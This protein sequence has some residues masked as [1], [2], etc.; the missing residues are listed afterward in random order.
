MIHLSWSFIR[1]RY[2]LYAGTLLTVICASMLMSSCLLLMFSAI[3][4]D[5]GPTRFQQADYLIAHP[6]TVVAELGEDR[7]TDDIPVIPPLSRE[8]ITEIERMLPGYSLYL[9]LTFYAQ[10]LDQQGNLLLNQGKYRTFGHTWSSYALT[11]DRLQAG[12]P[13]Q[14]PDEVV[15]DADL[16]R[17]SGYQIGDQVEVLT[18]AGIQTYTL[19]GI[20]K[21]EGGRAPFQGAMYF[22]ASHASLA[23]QGLPTAIGVKLNGASPLTE[24]QIERIEESMQVNVY[25]NQSRIKADSADVSL[26]YTGA[27]AVFGTMVGLT[28]F[29]AMF[30]LAST[31]SFSVQ[32]R[33]GDIALLRTIGS[34]TGQVKRM[35]ITETMLLSS[36]GAI[37]GSLLGSA[38]AAWLRQMFV[39]IGA[40]PSELTLISPR[41]T[42]GI[43]FGASLLISLLAA[44]GSSGS[45]TGM[46]ILK[47]VK[48]EVEPPAKSRW[49]RYMLGLI[50][51]G[52]GLAILIFTPM[53]GGMG[54]GM[55]FIVIAL[56]LITASLCGPILLALLHA[57]TR[58]LLVLVPG[59]A[60]PLA[61]AN[62]KRN[63]S[64]LVKVAI[65]LSMLLAVNAVMLLTS[66]WLMTLTEEHAA[67]RRGGG[68]QIQLAGG[69]GIPLPFVEQVM[70]QT[71]I[72]GGY[73]L[74]RSSVVVQKGSNL[75]EISAAGLYESG[76]VPLL[77]VVSGSLL[78]IES[79]GK[80]AISD[81][82]S[83]SLKVEVQD[84]LTLRLADGTKAEFEIGAIFQRM[85]GFEEIL[86]PW[87]PLYAHSDQQ[88]FQQL[89]VYQAPH[90][91]DSQFQQAIRQLETDWPPLHIRDFSAVEGD[92]D[93]QR[94]QRMALYIMLG[95]SVLF[96]SIAVMNT[97]FI[98][99]FARGKE[100]QDLRLAGATT[101]Q[102]RRMFR[103]ESLLLTWLA[104]VL[105]V[106]MVEAVVIPF[107][108]EQDGQWRW[109]FD[110]NLYVGLIGFTVILSMVSG[111]LASF[112]FM[113]RSEAWTRS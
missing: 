1:H 73:A 41:M 25:A 24:E 112:A 55:S 11:A 81:A 34:T 15:I 44:A 108:L 101:Q 71:E 45:A 60:L 103:W 88:L 91:S 96:T 95:I 66:T 57:A 54:V 64:Q 109:G 113:R 7:E 111:W 48:G 19:V 107:G 14:A 28:F 27:I 65:P 51:F 78:D 82:W 87:R 83:R 68:Y 10:L 33:F 13:V 80:I 20:G 92:Q 23:N 43:A 40:I 30:V 29:I 99:M 110:S 86:L 90:T 79:A 31:I 98:A 93:E 77:K 3:F 18:A 35:L 62:L 76:A 6:R 22:D 17:Q 104:T 67:E 94:V 21:D 46:D 85:E 97:Q 53:Q 38:G 75:E 32:Q 26:D 9:D 58:W 59:A 74:V 36:I 63:R 42:I 49:V 102:I 56:W 2:R 50:F 70:K 105:G 89:Q 12:R 8:E 84:R 52:G 72:R 5:K 69:Q 39:D 37:G 61:M 16:A 100:V 47:T 4:G 106:A